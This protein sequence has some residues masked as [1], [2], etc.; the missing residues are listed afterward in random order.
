MFAALTAAVA[1]VVMLASC[2]VAKQVPYFQDIQ[3]DS[4]LAIM[5]EPVTITFAPEDKVA[6]LVN[7]RDPQL[8]MTFNLPVVQRYIGNDNATLS[9]NNSLVGYTVDANGD[10]DFPVLGKVRIG[11][12]TREQAAE[13]IKDLLVSNSLI[14]DPVVTVEYMNLNVSVLG[15]VNKPGRYSIDRDRLTIFDALSMAG[16]L[17]I[18][19]LRE[20]VTVMRE[21]DGLQ[22]IYEVNLTSAEDVLT[23]PVYYLR[24]N[25]VIYVEPNKM[26]ANQ[27]TVNG[28]SFLSSSFW[29]SVASL[30]V[31]LG[32]L[33]FN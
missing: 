12:L 27:A 16:D 28:N 10:I 29:V 14:K 26:R 32:V 2:S 33:I 19:G 23:S 13:H 8:M 21:E 25:D 17:T 22:R 5:P 31:S 1:G 20:H 9:N 6:I 4:L 18:Y 24:Q 11:G 30:L 7:S 15:E 3:S